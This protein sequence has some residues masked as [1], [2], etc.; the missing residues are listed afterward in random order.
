ME[1]SI[2][3]CTRN[4]AASLARTLE[5]LAAMA[6]PEG[7]QWEVI[8]VDNGSSDDTQDV[9]HRFRDRLPLRSEYEAAPGLS[10]ARN[11]AVAAARGA[12]IL[13]TDDDV[14]VDR[15]WL[16]AYVK[17][18][19][20]SP[21]AVLFGGKIIPLLEEPAVPWLR[22]CW[23]LVGSVYACRDFGDEPLPIVPERI[24][25]GANYAVRMSE[26]RDYLYHSALGAGAL[27]PGEETEMIQAM[28]RD[29]KSGYWVPDATVRHWTP[30]HR[31]SLRYIKSYFRQQGAHLAFRNLD[32][33][34]YD[35]PRIFGGPRWL[36]KQ[37]M[38]E[39]CKF[40]LCRLTGSSAVWMRHFVRYALKSGEFDFYRRPIERLFQRDGQG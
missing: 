27:L 18:F 40:R 32:G 23:P 19:R 28:L 39:Y 8:V 29:G 7:L 9:V 30:R 38:I 4:R 21:E 10:N 22:D 34:R 14:L 36:L 37:L 25:Y 20:G 24:P 17:A 31:Q 6:V 11:C 33:L 5:S 15:R 26:Q 12:Y 3:I 2:A 13:W 16:A 35:G 1:A